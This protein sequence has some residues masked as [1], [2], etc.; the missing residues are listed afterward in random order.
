MEK[1]FEV[2]VIP[3]PYGFS[4]DGVLIRESNPRL[5][6]AQDRVIRIDE[7]NNPTGTIDLLTGFD[8]IPTRKEWNMK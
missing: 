6:L 1:T 2:V 4:I 5:V 7:N 3:T 8:K